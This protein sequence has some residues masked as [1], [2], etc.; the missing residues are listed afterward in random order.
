MPVDL[1]VNK[2]VKMLSGIASPIPAGVVERRSTPGTSRHFATGRCR[3]ST[4]L[5][6]IRIQRTCVLKP[7]PTIIVHPSGTALLPRGLSLSV[8]G[9][10]QVTRVYGAAFAKTRP[11]Q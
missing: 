5:A 2:G 9:L 8:G 11:R 7:G 6:K 4:P 10:G 3:A 1:V